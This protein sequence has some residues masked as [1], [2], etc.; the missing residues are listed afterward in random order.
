MTVGLLNRLRKICRTALVAIGIS[1]VTFQWLSL[2]FASTTHLRSRWAFYIT[3]AGA[4]ISSSSVQRSRSRHSPWCGPIVIL[5]P[6]AMA[7]LHC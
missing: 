3:T 1:I 4:R 7:Q 6:A 2:A 5:E